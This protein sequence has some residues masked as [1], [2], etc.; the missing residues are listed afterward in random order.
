MQRSPLVRKPEQKLRGGSPQE[1][2]VLRDEQQA[3][4]E[5]LDADDRQKPE[6]ARDDAKDPERQAYP[7]RLRVEDPLN[8]PG[9]AIRS[10]LLQ[11]FYRVIEQRLIA[12][13]LGL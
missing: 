13:L 12:L 8:D 1:R 5:K 10:F 3:D 9:D 2:H 7:A 11:C 6:K 4:R